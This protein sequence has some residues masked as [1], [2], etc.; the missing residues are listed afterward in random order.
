[1]KTDESG[2]SNM[3]ITGTWIQNGFNVGCVEAGVMAGMQAARAINRQ[4][5]KMKIVGESDI[6]EH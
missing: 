2:F 5:F 4:H 3:Y 6:V 1:M